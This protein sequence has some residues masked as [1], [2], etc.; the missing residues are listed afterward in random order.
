[1]QPEFLLKQ[2][3]INKIISIHPY[4]DCSHHINYKLADDCALHGQVQI[5][6]LN[7]DGKVR[8]MINFMRLELLLEPAQINKIISIQP[9]IFTYSVESN[10]RPKVDFFQTLGLEKVEVGR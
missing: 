4:I 10:L 5:L 8:D 3:Q 2:Q 7:L 1:L 9:S 6:S